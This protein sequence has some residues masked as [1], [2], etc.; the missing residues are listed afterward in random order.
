V[1][2]HDLVEKTECTFR[3]MPGGRPEPGSGRTF[4]DQ[5]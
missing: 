3:T 4:S 2:G 5:A 1:F